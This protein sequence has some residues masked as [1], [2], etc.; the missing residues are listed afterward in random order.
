[1]RIHAIQTGEVRIRERMRRGVRGPARRAAIATG[2]WSGP[3][4]ILAWAIEHDE[5]VI[6]VDTGQRLDGRDTPFARFEVS[7]PD[8]FGHG[9][10]AAGIDP[11]DVGTAVVTHLHGDHM[12]GLAELPNASVLI[13]EAEARHALTPAAR[14]IRRIIH[15]PLPTG[16]RLNPVALDGPPLGAFSAS[17]ALTADATVAIVPAPGHTPGHA[18]V[19]VVDGD[20]HVLI[21]GDLAYDQAQLLDLHVDAVSPN[22]DV[23]RET[24][25]TVLRHARLAPTIFLAAHDPASHARLAARE[26]LPAA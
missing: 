17:R 10:R 7:E 24:L 14:A 11:A 15:A 23:A 9:L 12:N 13:S 2:P 8:H 25:R 1:M 4:P 3:L 18:A 16:V 22:A 21:A 19:L 26:P 6:V 5:G 20:R